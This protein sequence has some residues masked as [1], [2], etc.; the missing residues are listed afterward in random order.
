MKNMDE[1]NTS[2]IS[3]IAQQYSDFLQ[4]QI[5]S[6]EAIV[7]SMTKSM[8]T[9][10]SILQNSISQELQQPF[11]NIFVSNYKK[12]QVIQAFQEC[13]LWLAPSMINLFDEITKLYYE[14]KKQNIP[15]V[16]IR[17]YKKDNWDILTKTV[18]KWESNVFF[19]P[20]MKIIHDALEAHIRGKFTLSVPS[21]LPQIEGITLDIIKKYDLRNKDKSLVN[22]SKRKK[23]KGLNMALSEELLDTFS[24]NEWF[25]VDSFLFYVENTLYFSPSGKREKIEELK[26]EKTLKRNPIL[27]GIQLNY[28][29]PINSL[30][31]FL[32]LDVLSLLNDNQGQ[33]IK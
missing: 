4:H 14:G 15:N 28:A 1:I 5:P 27:H 13:G 31:C 19:H 7:A 12:G 20:R 17:Y 29:T 6:I 26:G 24:V 2:I 33:L 16:I 23:A 22:E 25:A 10:L 30:R 18:K 8:S 11:L 9:S 21:L 32:A 3:Y